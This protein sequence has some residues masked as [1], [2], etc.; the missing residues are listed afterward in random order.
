MGL[1]R[2][3]II[4][5]SGIFPPFL[6][7][8]RAEILQFALLHASQVSTRTDLQLA[9]PCDLAVALEAPLEASSF[10]PPSTARM[11]LQHRAVFSAGSRL[12]DQLDT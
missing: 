12:H 11:V 9:D 5:E 6:P 3:F 2:I 10:N 1:E 8:F 7:G 4:N